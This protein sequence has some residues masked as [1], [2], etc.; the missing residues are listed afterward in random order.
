MG[1]F[2]SKFS[3]IVRHH[4]G[5]PFVFVPLFSGGNILVKSLSVFIAHFP[6]MFL[7]ELYVKV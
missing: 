3:A 4:T 6:E 1:S 7:E 2:S 5:N